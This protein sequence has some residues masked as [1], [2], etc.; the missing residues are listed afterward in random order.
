MYVGELGEIEA[1]DA[2]MLIVSTCHCTQILHSQPNVRRRKNKGA[3]VE[4]QKKTTFSVYLCE[5]LSP[6]PHIGD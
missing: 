5:S 6:T 2:R 4:A 1:G 3:S